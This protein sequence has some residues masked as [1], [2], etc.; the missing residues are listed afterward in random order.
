MRN[1][2]INGLELQA[3]DLTVWQEGAAK[4]LTETLWRP[5]PHPGH[6]KGR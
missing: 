3:D 2:S 6:C 1:M 5:N 4:N